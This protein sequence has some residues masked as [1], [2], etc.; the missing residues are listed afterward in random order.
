MA[1]E[2][3]GPVW[4]LVASAWA[5]VRLDECVEREPL[6]RVIDTESGV[7]VSGLT[8][9]EDIAINALPGG[10]ASN[11]MFC[12]MDGWYV[13]ADGSLV[14]LDEC[15]NYDCAPDRYQVEWCDGRGAGA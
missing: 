13:G 9:I 7:D 12:D 1:N 11:L 10:F 2:K 8:E 6:F 5:N 15:G 3:A 14:L 4:A